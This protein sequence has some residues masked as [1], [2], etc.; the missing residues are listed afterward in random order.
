MSVARVLL[1]PLLL[2]LAVSVG[3]LAPASRALAAFEPCPQISV[4]FFCTVDVGN[5]S[6][7]V[8]ASDIEGRELGIEFW[9]SE[10]ELHIV[11]HA[12]VLYDTA[13][14]VFPSF[15]LVGLPVVDAVTRQVFVQYMEENGDFQVMATFTFDESGNQTLLEEEIR[16]ES[17]VEGV[18]SRLY[19]VNEFELGPEVFDQIVSAT[20]G[21]ALITQI[22]G[23]WSST[24]ESLT[25]PTSFETGFL[26]TLD[27]IVLG[28]PLELN[29]NAAALGPARLASAVAWDR[30]LD[31]GAETVIRMRKT[32]TLPEPASS[33]G[34]VAGLLALHC[35]RPRR[36]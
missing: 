16:I 5:A 36:V 6:I 10:G 32:V 1:A 17:F 20:L 31:A 14:Q 21:G 8:G 22:D 26:T 25:P 27:S 34:L 24:V 19:A 7:T 3:V 33:V 12:Y 28:S 13:N 2:A 35:A 30:D 23:E 18:S 9:T 15:L 29:G 4:V 11:R